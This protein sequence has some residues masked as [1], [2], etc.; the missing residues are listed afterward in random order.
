MIYYF[1]ILNY[2]ANTVYFIFNL[3]KHCLKTEVFTILR[4]IVDNLIGIELT[5]IN[6]CVLL[7]IL[8]FQDVKLK[9]YFIIYIITFNYVK[10][11]SNAASIS[12]TLSTLK[13]E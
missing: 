13:M 8:L 3:Q 4:N 12:C 9:K 1:I 7:I 10:Y 5:F 11:C 2:I 6:R